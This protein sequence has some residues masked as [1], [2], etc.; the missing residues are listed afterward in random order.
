MLTKTDLTQIGKLMRDESETIRDDITRE[1]RMAMV[2]I[3]TRVDKLENRLKNVEIKTTGMQND[4]KKL[5]NKVTRMH[6]E[7][8]KK[9]EDSVLYSDNRTIELE[10]RVDKIENQ[11]EAVIS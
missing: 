2:R 8:L 9:M 3:I 10:K 7:L 5:E 1:V 6:K 4:I 11:L